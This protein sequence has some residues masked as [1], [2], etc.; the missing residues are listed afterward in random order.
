V[1]IQQKCILGLKKQLRE[2]IEEEK[3]NFFHP[4]NS[5]VFKQAKFEIN[6]CT[7]N[8]NY[9]KID[10]QLVELQTQAIVKLIDH[11]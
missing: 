6:N 7:Y 1:S 2:F 5:I 9:E 11:G 4:N 3:K 8:I 10:K